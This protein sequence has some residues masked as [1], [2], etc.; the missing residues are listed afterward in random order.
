MTC[1]RNILP[2]PKRSPMMPMPCISGPSMTVSG[3]L[4]SARA[5]STS[6]SMNL[7]MPL[8][9]PWCRRSVY[10]PLRHASFAFCAAGPA[11]VWP[12]A[13]LG[14]FFTSSANSRKRS[15]CFPSADLFNITSS[16]SARAF[17]S[18]SVYRGRAPG[19]TMD[20][21]RP[22]GTAWYKKTECMAS[23]S[24]LRPRNENDRLLRPPLNETHGH[25]RLISATALMKS[26]AYELCSGRPVAIVSTLQSKMMSSGGKSSLVR[27][28]R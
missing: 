1:G 10:V 24:E 12:A 8:I 28:S 26:T 25:V 4:R 16:I 7:S 6:P 13:A 20:M 22:F 11:P 3:T 21:F 18:M 17:G 23:R 27:I 19:F 14:G 5:S 9:R 15:T 2:A